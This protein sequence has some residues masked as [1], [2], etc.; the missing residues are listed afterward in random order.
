MDLIDRIFSLNT[1]DDFESAAAEVFAMQSKSVE[2]YARY[3]DLI[4][5]NP[6]SFTT[7]DRAPF[8]PIGFFKESHVIVDGFRAEKI[9]RSSRTTGSVAS[10]HHVADLS[11]YE[12]SLMTGFNMFYGSP[13]EFALLALLPSYLERDDASLVHMAR[14]L[15]NESG[16]PL[17][18]F[19]L[20]DFGALHER[21][22][23]LQQAG[24]RFM[25][26]GVPFA[27]LDLLESHH[28]RLGDSIIL[29][30]GGMKGRRKEMIREELHAVLC[31]GFG[32]DRIH[33]EYGMTELLSQAWSEGN[34][35][36]RPVPWMKVV[37]FD[38]NDPFQPLPA[39][40]TGRLHV[41][42]LANIHSCSFIATDDL[43]RVNE[44]GSFEVLGRI[45]NSDIRGCNL[46]AV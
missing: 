30:T 22:S 20:D 32:V 19:F 36:Y 46:L 26:L 16:H 4:G 12:R 18:G 28:Y 39:G 1:P 40:Q 14:V 42:D 33:S 5:I 29:E 38:I 7:S 35:I 34:G 10:E 8:L 37:A 41:I 23:A 13:K 15:M 11:V 2:A 44:D 27:L 17:N 6:D 25:L 9:F 45:D 3:I 43:C 21:I 24:Q 31:D